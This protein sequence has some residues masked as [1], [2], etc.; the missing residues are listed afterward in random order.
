MGIGISVILLAVGAIL[1]WAIEADVSG[2]SLE[3]VGVILMIVGAIGLIWSLIAASSIGPWHRE[4]VV[5]R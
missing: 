2:V 5:E 1:T 3:T 4:R